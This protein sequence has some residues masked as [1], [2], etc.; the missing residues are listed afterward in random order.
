MDLTGEAGAED[1]GAVADAGANAGAVAR[2]LNRRTEG[3]GDAVV[4]DSVVPVAA[5]ERRSDNSPACL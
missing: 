2:F 5:Q 1:A 3:A 4:G